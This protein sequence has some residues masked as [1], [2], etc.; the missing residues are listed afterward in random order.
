MSCDELQEHLQN[1]DPTLLD[2]SSLDSPLHPLTRSL[3][4]WVLHP[5]T[6]THTHTQTH[7]HRSTEICPE[8][9]PYLSPALEEGSAEEALPPGT[10]RDQAV[11][12]ENAAFYFLYNRLLD[13]LWSR[14][15]VNGQ[16][17]EVLQS[18]GVGQV[19][20]RDALYRLGVAH[21]N[22]QHEDAE[23]EEAGGDGAE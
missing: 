9:Q 10:L 1:S 17:S 11:T 2:P 19:V 23:Q 4:R 18:C 22:T 14:E 7:S 12:F 8:L 13:F 21:I 3:S 6:H 16:I 20:I 15:V 5:P